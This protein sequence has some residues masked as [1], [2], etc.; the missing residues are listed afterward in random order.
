MRRIAKCAVA[1][2]VAVILLVLSL[3]LALYAWDAYHVRHAKRAVADCARA[4]AQGAPVPQL[5]L[6]VSLSR[7][8]LSKA[9]AAGYEV[10]GS[11]A[12][13][14]AL[15]TYDVQVRV[16]NGDRYGFEVVKVEREWRLHCCRHWT[17]EQLENPP[18]EKPVLSLD[19]AATRRAAGV[20]R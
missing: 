15:N 1:A 19:A 17:A 9:F 20:F 4:L 16:A 2:F 12:T 10:V 18:R 7:A 11:D 13:E 5:Q 3:P 14:S 8:D 6:R